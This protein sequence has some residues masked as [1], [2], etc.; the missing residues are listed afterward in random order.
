MSIKSNSYFSNNVC[1][2]LNVFIN[3]IIMSSFLSFV[4]FIGE[5]RLYLLPLLPDIWT[6]THFQ[7]P[8]VEQVVEWALVKQRARVRSRSGQ[9]S[10]V[11]FFRGFSSPVREYQETLGPPKVPEYHMAVVIIIPYSL[12]WDDWVC[13]WCVLS[14]MFV[15]SRRWPRH[16]AYLSSG[17]ALHVLVW[18]KKYVCDP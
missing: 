9:V 11:W 6:F 17:E 3:F 5:Y 18:S 4:Y 14:F 7:V 10:W 15:L 1:N 16:W 13:A 8:I 2:F 12:C